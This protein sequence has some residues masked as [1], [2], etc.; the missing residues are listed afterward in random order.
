M[1]RRLGRPKVF[2]KGAFNHFYRP[3]KSE[4][5][6]SG[7]VLIVLERVPQR[8]CHAPFLDFPSTSASADEDSKGAHGVSRC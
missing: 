4:D 1:G 7:A 5:T 8:L 6:V 3:E 2:G